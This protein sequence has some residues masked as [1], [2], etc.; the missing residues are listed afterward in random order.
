MT[1]PHDVKPSDLVTLADAAEEYGY[2]IDRLRR[3]LKDGRL[4]RYARP[5]DLRRAWLDRNELDALE[6]PRRV[7]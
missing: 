7:A 2:S 5:T 4:T 6:E 3:W 1:A